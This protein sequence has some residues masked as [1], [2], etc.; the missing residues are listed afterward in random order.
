MFYIRVPSRNSISY[1]SGENAPKCK[2]LMIVTV[3]ILLL[4][5]F[6]IHEKKMHFCNVFLRLLE[7][8]LIYW[9]IGN[10]CHF[11]KVLI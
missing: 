11:S 5:L 7:V 6:C 8:E 4:S 2:V 10:R 9:R 1:K 3:N